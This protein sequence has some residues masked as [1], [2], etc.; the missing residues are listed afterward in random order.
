MNGLVPRTQSWL[1]DFIIDLNR[2]GKT[3][4]SSLTCLSLFRK[5]LK[6]DEDHT[7]DEDLDTKHLVDDIGLLKRANL[8]NEF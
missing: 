4:I 6:V 3:I 5:F 8:V 1:T 7:I 2:A